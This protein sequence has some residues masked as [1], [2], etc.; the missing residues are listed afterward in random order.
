MFLILKRL[1]A[2]GSLEVW[3]CGWWV[4]G[5]SSWI[6]G[7]GRRYGMCNTERVDLGNV[8]IKSGV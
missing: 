5:T 8:E 1:K 4:M 6:Q 7:V 3:L 2:P